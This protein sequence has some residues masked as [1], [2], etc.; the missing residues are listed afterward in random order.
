VWCRIAPIGG[1]QRAV[2]VD[3]PSLAAIVMLSG[4]VGLI[5]GLAIIFEDDDK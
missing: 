2:V 1:A 5:I 4:I 3:D